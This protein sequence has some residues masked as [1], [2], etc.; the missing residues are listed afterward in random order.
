MGH[1]ASV[2]EIGVNSLQ[3]NEKGKN[4]LEDRCVCGKITL[5]SIF[6]K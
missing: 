6:K 4:R 2:R 1:A 3:Y 5:K